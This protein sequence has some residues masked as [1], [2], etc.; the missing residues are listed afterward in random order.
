MHKHFV[1]YVFFIVRFRNVSKKGY[2]YVYKSSL[3]SGIKYTRT[4]IS[5]IERKKKIFWERISYYYC[6]NF[7]S[8]YEVKKW[9]IVPEIKKWFMFMRSGWM[10]TIPINHWS[11]IKSSLTVKFYVS[12]KIYLPFFFFL[13]SITLVHH[14]VTS[15]EYKFYKIKEKRKNH[16]YHYY[17]MERH[18]YFDG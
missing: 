1:P 4:V 12:S 13:F 6:K 10:L 16:S 9:L 18:Y 11:N 2:I 3:I 5:I 8:S 15:F 7:R 14:C 17:A